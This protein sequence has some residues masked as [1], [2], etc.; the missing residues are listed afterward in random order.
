MQ[1]NLNPVFEPNN[2]PELPKAGFIDQW[3]FESPLP[4]SIA[5]VAIGVI[6][7]GT[8]RHSEHAKRI[9]I[10]TFLAA[11]ALGAAVFVAGQLVTT[12]RE[13]LR[14][15]SKQ[16]VT[17]AGAG[18]GVVLGSLLDKQVKLKMAMVS[19]SGRDKLVSLAKSRAAPMINSISTR[20]VRAGL[21]GPQVAR[22]HIKVR[23]KG[24]MIPPLSWWRVDWFR[25]STESN[26]WR[27]SHIEPLWIQGFSNPAGTN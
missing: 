21:D 5:L 22:T 27:V 19:S 8:I 23:V 18:D 17:S 3:V 12:D 11:A 15:L 16:L 14:D 1:S 7:L 20:E 6:V 13:Y 2:L 9:G 4:L 25:D 24:D 10:P 26:E